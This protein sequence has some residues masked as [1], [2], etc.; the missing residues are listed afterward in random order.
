MH[1]RGPE[2][3]EGAGGRAQ[4]WKGE[5]PGLA[6]WASMPSCPAAP[7]PGLASHLAWVAECLPTQLGW[8]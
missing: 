8:L 3:L 5:G 2:K 4:G 1:W 7:L 6:G